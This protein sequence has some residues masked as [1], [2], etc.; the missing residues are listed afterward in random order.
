MSRCQT[1]WCKSPLSM[2][3]IPMSN[4][5]SRR[6][7][8]ETRHLLVMVG[9]IA[10][11]IFTVEVLIMLMLSGWNLDA[12]V[13]KEG[14]LD[15]TILTL[16][17]S[18]LIYLWVA[19]PYADATRKARAELSAQLEKTTRLLDQNEKLRA[20]LQASNET[21][22]ETHENVLQKIGAELHDGP[23]QLLSFTL[24]KL[25]RLGKTVRRVGDQASIADL[26]KLREVMAQALREVRDI[27]TGLSLPELASAS[28]EEAIALAVQRH[29]EVT[30]TRIAVAMADMPGAASLAQKICAYRFI[31]EALTNA[32]KHAKCQ[33]IAIAAMGREHMRISVTDDGRGFNPQ[34][35]RRGGLGLPGMRAR[36]QAL[37]GRL[38][39]ASA[40]G[41][42][43]TV[44]AVFELKPA[45]INRL[46]PGEAPA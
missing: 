21:T 17:S 3:Q 19:R 12:A 27:S 31:Q 24:L 32:F 36:V 26:D 29:E 4:M 6:I 7:G 34:S 28:I 23:A 30:G 1:Q 2:N 42:G 16:V 46:S 43:T 35:V 38:E 25:D 40:V 20:D 44:T 22:A 13:I 39:I 11:I 45:E 14:L 33:Q 37:G 15:A 5:P 41:E 18:P 8:Q 10:C 9:K